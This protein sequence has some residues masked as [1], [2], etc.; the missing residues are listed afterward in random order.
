MPSGF[1]KI[2][3]VSSVR[4]PQVG[5]FVRKVPMSEVND[6]NSPERRLRFFRFG[7]LAITGSA[8]AMGTVYGWFVTLGSLTGGLLQGLLWGVFAGALSV[9]IYFLY[10]KFMVKPE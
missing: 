7:L 10:K 1:A 6:R 5:L 2:D 9:I 3:W 4:A 8:F